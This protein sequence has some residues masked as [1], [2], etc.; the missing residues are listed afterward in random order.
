M[1]LREVSVVMEK[2]MQHRILELLAGDSRLTPGQIGAML[3]LP[4]AAVAQEIAALEADRRLVRYGALVDWERAGRDRVVALIDVKVHPQREFGFDKVARRIY[5]FS[6]VTACY[7]MSGTYDLAVQVEG[8][9]LKDVALFVAEK[10]APIEGVAG[11][12]THFILKRYKQDGVVLTD[13]EDE[14]RLAVTP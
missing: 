5:G 9:S 2:A 13:P 14:R 1:V 6:E 12:T 11:T 7:L 8:T 4:A 10:L 3:D